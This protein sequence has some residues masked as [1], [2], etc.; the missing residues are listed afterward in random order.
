MATE[1][2]QA[3]IELYRRNK[4]SPQ[5]KAAV[6]E[7]S[8]RG[9]FELPK[10]QPT[11]DEMIQQQGQDQA[12]RELAQ[13]QGVFDSFLIGVGKGMTDI[14]RGIGLVDM[15]D[16]IERRAFEKLE[17]ERP[18]SAG[19]GEIVG[20]TAPFLA[21]ATAIGGIASTGARI[22]SATGLGALEGG[23]VS[24]GTGGDAGDIAQSSGIGGAIAG[25]LEAVS[26]ILGR[27]VRKTFSKLTG[28]APASGVVK[29]V[30][31]DGNPSKELLDSL[32]EEGLKW[33]DL[34]L[35]FKDMIAE[36]PLGADPQQAARLAR[37]KEVGADPTRGQ[38]TRDFDQLKRE[39]QLLVSGAESA[40]DEFR[41]FQLR[42][43]QGITEYLNDLVQRQG[44]S[45]SVGDD[46]KDA[47]T[48]RRS[49]LKRERRNAYK[50]LAEQ[51][52]NIGQAAISPNA[53]INGL[54]DARTIRSISRAA[55]QQFNALNDWLVEFGL[56][57]MPA[58]E[59]AM[60]GIEPEVLSLSN[61]EEFRKGLNRISNS[62]QTGTIDNLI[63]PLKNAL[64]D[65]VGMAAEIFSGS[66][67]GIAATAKE[68]RRTN[69]ALREEFD[70]AKITSKLIDSVKRGST[71][72]K[73]EASQ[74]YGR[75]MANNSPIENLDRVIESLKKSGSD[76]KKALQGMR[77]QA[78]MDLLDSAF[79]AGSRQVKGERIFSPTPFN[80][81]FDKLKPKLEKLFAD[82]PEDWKKLQ[83]AV[84]V[85]KDLVPPE[86]A[87]PRGSAG[88]ILDIAKKTG[89]Y[90]IMAKV[91]GADV[92]LGIADSMAKRGKDEAAV[93]KAINAKPEVR[94]LAGSIDRELPA[95]A[96]ALGIAGISAESGES[97]DDNTQ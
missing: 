75:L 33:D 89:I 87:V 85:S 21:P 71:Q 74:V 88:V 91:P 43:S 69:M 23:I 30:D 93:M 50:K 1:Q 18:F 77:A 12:L 41:N 49:T 79:R 25:T 81:Q 37:F 46:V 59:M 8:R 94:A 60:K 2:Q 54:P 73:I 84:R 51:A 92:L 40:G 78:V 39:Q 65:E 24:S 26:P 34:T 38:L 64:D 17:E 29:L 15:P 36:S 97:E 10:A 66:G 86:G 82:S 7:L 42:Q 35:E 9:V 95:L 80:N 47:L 53:I 28:K 90:S 48:G 32:R 6:E 83:S 13:K 11:A 63:L 70:D 52:E 44:L 3:L 5:Q 76:G 56:R 61:F 96:S 72:P 16:D 20:Q 62:D 22:A 4:L 14:G 68:A 19:A 57:E 58:E 67:G 31:E 55:P 27:V 45:P